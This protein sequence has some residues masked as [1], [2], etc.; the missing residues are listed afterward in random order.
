MRTEDIHTLVH[1]RPYAIN[2]I[3]FYDL[4]YEIGKELTPYQRTVS[5][6]HLS[7]SAHHVAVQ[8]IRIID[9]IL[10]EHRDAS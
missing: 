5:E 4:M 1:L 3:G 2:V 10:D 7:T 9:R 8:L 6:A